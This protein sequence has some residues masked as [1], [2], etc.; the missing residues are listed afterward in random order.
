MVINLVCS[1]FCTSI[2][3][4]LEDKVTEFFCVVN[5]FCKFF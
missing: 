2:A 3:S 5:K 1:I 4:T